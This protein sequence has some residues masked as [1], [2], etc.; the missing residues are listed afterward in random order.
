MLFRPYYLPC[1]IFPT[2]RN[3]KFVN[4]VSKNIDEISESYLGECVVNL[5]ICLAATSELTG[6]PTSFPDD[7]GELVDYDTMAILHK[8]SK[9]LFTR[10]ASCK[11]E[12]YTSDFLSGM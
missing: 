11:T 12:I 7:V 4:N 2:L 9:N 1:S 10:A 3:V 8:N 6:F 5:E